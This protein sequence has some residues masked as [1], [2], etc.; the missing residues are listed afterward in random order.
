[1][2]PSKG[3]AQIDYDDP[4]YRITPVQQAAASCT[5]ALLTSVIMTPLDVVKIRM[6]AQQ[7]ATNSCF[8]Y[9]NG[10]MDHICSCQ[11]MDPKN[12]WYKRPSQFSGTL[13]AFVQIGR[14]EGVTSLWSGLSPTLVLSIPA[15]ICYFVT[16][17]QLRLKLK[18]KYNSNKLP[19]E[20]ARQPFWIPL[21]SG[22]SARVLSVTLVNPLELIRTKMQSQK[23][24]YLELGEAL[25]NL[26]RTDGYKGL[27]RGVFPTLLR[28]VPFSAI[29]W[30]SYESIKSYMGCDHPSFRQSF[31]GGAISGSIAATI[32]VPFDV[33]K[34]HQQIEFGS[35]FFSENGKPAKRQRRSTAMVFRDIYSQYGVRGL[36]TGLTPRL[37]KVAPACAIMISSFEYGKVF[38]NRPKTKPEDKMV[39]LYNIDQLLQTTSSAQNMYYE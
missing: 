17:E 13:D 35:D 32:T 8:L 11:P 14:A 30:M 38:F 23:L 7:K 26:V 16:Y 18:A 22:A 5:G 2:S 1:M 12:P 10:L 21:V 25:K 39:A 9:C 33:V 15:T 6:Q 3:P 37:I 28:D 20:S 34:T 4:K 29:Y 31:I 19:N 27:W 24:S 36:Y